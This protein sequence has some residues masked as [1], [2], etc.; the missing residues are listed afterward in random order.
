MRIQKLEDVDALGYWQEYAASQLPSIDVTGEF[1]MEQLRKAYLCG[2]WTIL[3]LEDR[4]RRESTERRAALLDR[5]KGEC[6]SAFQIMD[7][8]GHQS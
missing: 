1:A 8:I 3:A 2:M 7:G 4:L 5:L 6:E